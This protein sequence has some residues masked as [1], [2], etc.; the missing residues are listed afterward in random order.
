MSPLF[1]IFT[2]TNAASVQTLEDTFSSFRKLL[3]QCSKWKFRSADIS[4]Y[5][6]LSRSRVCVIIAS[7]VPG[8][9]L[10]SMNHFSTLCG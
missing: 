8:G 4:I 3:N 7:G 1:C 5:L 9:T 6:S 10:D 2:S